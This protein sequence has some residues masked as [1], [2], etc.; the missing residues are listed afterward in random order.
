MRAYVD[1]GNTII[2]ANDIK[3]VILYK[4]EVPNSKVSVI[5][6]D[7]SLSSTTNIKIANSQ[8]VHSIEFRDNHMTVWH[9]YQIGSGKK[10]EYNEV[11]EYV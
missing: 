9:Y 7:K 8:S 11:V 4:S 6:I 10:A 1:G 5:E 2:D 3:E